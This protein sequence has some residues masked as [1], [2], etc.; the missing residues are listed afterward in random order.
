MRGVAI[1]LAVLGLP[2]SRT[3]RLERLCPRTP[4][5]ARRIG[6]SNRTERWTADWREESRIGRDAGPPS[7][8]AFERVCSRTRKPVSALGNV[9][10]TASF[11]ESGGRR[12]ARRTPRA[13]RAARLPDPRASD[14]ASECGR[15]R[16]RRR[17]CRRRNSC[18]RSRASWDSSSHW[19][20]CCL[21]NGS[22]CRR[23][24]R[25]RRLR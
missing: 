18:R 13:A 9:R 4:R 5:G 16:R 2:R 20:R 22:S 21:R 17:G 3:P 8:D 11:P 25:F 7:H 24:H 14:R 12:P 23:C 15:I 19:R 6:A 10:P 1:G